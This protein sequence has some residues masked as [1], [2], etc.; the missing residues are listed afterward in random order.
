MNS[1]VL[2]FFPFINGFL[3]ISI[4]MKSYYSFQPLPDDQIVKI[5][6]FHAMIVALCYIADP[7]KS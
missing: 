6:V 1:L 7:N 2:S 4:T 5:P 3:A